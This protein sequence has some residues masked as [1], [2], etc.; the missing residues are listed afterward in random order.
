MRFIRNIKDIQYIFDNV[1]KME[2]FTCDFLLNT[3]VFFRSIY[4][5][6]VTRIYQIFD[7][8]IQCNFYTFCI[9]N[10]FYEQMLQKGMMRASR[11]AELI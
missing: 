10:T 6:D 1:G 7:S 5:I 9:F 2:S 11:T 8:T 4:P 3:V